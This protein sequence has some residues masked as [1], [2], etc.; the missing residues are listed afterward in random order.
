MNIYKSADTNLLII[1]T[2]TRIGIQVR[3]LGP[4]SCLCKLPRRFVVRNELILA[5]G[6][7]V[8]LDHFQRR[9]PIKLITVTLPEVLSL[10]NLVQR[11]L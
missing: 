9:L 7:F 4:W 8:A 3:S 10:F 1:S 2:P 11:V 6:W 5:L